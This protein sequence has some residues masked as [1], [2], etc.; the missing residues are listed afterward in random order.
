MISPTAMNLNPVAPTDQALKDAIAVLSAIQGADALGQQ[1]FLQSVLDRASSAA[2]A[3]LDAGRADIARQQAAVD[4]AMAAVVNSQAEYDRQTAALDGRKAYLQQES[5]AAMQRALNQL[6]Q[7]TMLYN[8]AQA[9]K[10]KYEKL[11]ADLKA[12]VGA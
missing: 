6:G 9:A 10:T 2:N 11:A 4:S 5:D 12:R 8:D 1:T 7:A 3:V